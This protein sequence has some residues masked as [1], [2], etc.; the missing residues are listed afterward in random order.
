M[1]LSMVLQICSVPLS[2]PSC[3]LCPQWQQG[4]EG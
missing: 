1:S 2:V 4:C 3:S